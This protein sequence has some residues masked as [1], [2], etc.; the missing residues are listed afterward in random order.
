M[1]KLITITCAI[2]I[3]SMSYAQKNEIKTLEKALKSKNFAAAKTA[4]NSAD[5]LVGNMDDKTKTKFYFLKAQALYAG[6]AGTDPDIDASIKTLDDLKTLESKIGKLKYTQEANT[7]A[8]TN[9]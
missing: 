4:V 5:A 2:L 9:L 6:G 7:I 1:K 8:L 3:S